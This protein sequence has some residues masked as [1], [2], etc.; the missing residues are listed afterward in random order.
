MPWLLKSL[1]PMETSNISNLLA[2]RTPRLYHQESKC[3]CDFRN[4]TNGEVAL[5]QIRV[6]LWEHSGSFIL[7]LYGA[8]FSFSWYGSWVTCRCSYSQI[9]IHHHLWETE[10]QLFKGIW[11]RK[12]LYL[13]YIQQVEQ[14]EFAFLYPFSVRA[15]S[16]PTIC[17]AHPVVHAC[18]TVP[19]DHCSCRGHRAQQRP[20]GLADPPVLHLDNRGGGLFCHWSGVLLLAG[21]VLLVSPAVPHPI[22]AHAMG[23][24]LDAFT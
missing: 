4:E 11:F 5:Y 16:W 21:T 3:C 15:C 13:P 2:C 9:D 1:C 19:G 17:T 10:L 24:V 20:H 7:A 18:P 23:C 14:C 22:G 8:L 12:L 6:I